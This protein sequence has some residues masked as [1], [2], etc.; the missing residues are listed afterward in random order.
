MW[1]SYVKGTIAYLFLLVISAPALAASASL[2][3]RPAGPYPPESDCQPVGFDEPD[4]VAV[5]NMGNIYVANE[6]GPDAV[7]EVTATGT[8]RTILNRRAEP[9]RSGHYFGLSLAMGPRN[10]VY[11]AVQ[12]RGTIEKL[13]SN[14]TLAVV[15]GKPGDRRLADGPDS[16]AR[17]KAPNAIAISRSGVIY[18]SDS[19]TIRKVLLN[20]EISTL[21]GAAHPKAVQPSSGGIPYYLDGIGTHARFGAA[22]GIAVDGDGSVYVTDGYYYLADWF[23]DGIMY[24]VVS[25]GFIRKVTPGGAV[26]T[27]AGSSRLLGQGLPGVA[28][29]VS[30]YSL[31][32]IAIDSDGVI[33]VST[34]FSYPSIKRLS[35]GSV[36]DVVSGPDYEL[37]Y[38]P[39]GLVAPTGVAVDRYG[40]LYTVN[41]L[42]TVVLPGENVDWLNRIVNSHVQTLCEIKSSANS[43]SPH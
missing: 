20:G 34:P 43:V 42:N 21:A 36:D 27:V 24:K 8:M 6:A 14:G 16:V 9:I 15:A 32:G 25:I 13:N 11:I 19:S 39:T 3:W 35:R 12:Q 7:V 17:L 28:S 23:T 29:K 22:N 33:Y 26:T 38:A 5:D 40:T 2:T 30:F 41:D 4:A 1:S 10:D 18:F 31:F 37:A